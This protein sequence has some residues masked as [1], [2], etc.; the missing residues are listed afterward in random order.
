MPDATVFQRTPQSIFD[1]FGTRQLTQLAFNVLANKTY[2]CEYCI[3]ISMNTAG[4]NM[5]LSVVGP[6][7]IVGLVTQALVINSNQVLLQRIMIGSGTTWTIATAPNVS[8]YYVK[9]SCQVQNGPNV[10]TLIPQLARNG[11]G[12]DDASVDRPSG[13]FLKLLN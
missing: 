1:G 9:L 11:A 6:V 2:Y 12:T 4:T 8:P 10:G 3:R 13:G 7:G 5:V